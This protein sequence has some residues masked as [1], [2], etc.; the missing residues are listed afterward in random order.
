MRRVLKALSDA[1]K[2]VLSPLAAGPKA[3]RTAPAAK[4]SKR[5]RP[6][7][8]GRRAATWP[9][10]KRPASRKAAVWALGIFTAVI[11]AVITAYFT[12][13]F[14]PKKLGATLSKL[15]PDTNVTLE[16]YLKQSSLSPDE[17]ALEELRQVGCLIHFQVEIEGFSGRE[18]A[19]RWSVYD[20][21][22]RS[23]IE[24][25]DPWADV[26]EPIRFTPEQVTD[27]AAENF[28]VPS[29]DTDRPFF[30]RVELYD[31]KGVR[32]TFADTEPIRFHPRPPPA[33]E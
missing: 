8:R 22:S 13:T 11:T 30:V 20:A 17:Y 15:T 3:K 19:A 12:G 16:E 33:N 31:D 6:S 7:A 32:L 28:W 4:K 14:A 25:P 1:F 23:R 24:L 27:S 9:W 26:Q 29:L 18:C 10:H 2:F 21:K 5:P